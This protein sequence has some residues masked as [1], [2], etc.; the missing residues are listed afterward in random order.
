MGSGEAGKSYAYELPVKVHALLPWNQT[1]LL[2]TVTVVGRAEAKARVKQ[3]NI[4]I[5]ELYMHPQ[6]KTNASTTHLPLSSSPL[7]CYP[8]P[9]I[10]FRPL[11]I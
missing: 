5:S 3:I 4:F 1:V 2:S 9:A 7:L 11:A 6:K 10:L 8:R